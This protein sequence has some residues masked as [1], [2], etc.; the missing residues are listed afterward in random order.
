[1]IATIGDDLELPCQFTGEPAP[2]VSW[3]KDD[4]AVSKGNIRSSGSLVIESFQ[5]EDEGSYHCTLANDIG[6]LRSPETLVL[7]K[8]AEITT[9]VLITK[10]LVYLP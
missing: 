4:V 1:V 9:G 8:N 10:R 5:V 6:S 7:S 3:Y 2:S